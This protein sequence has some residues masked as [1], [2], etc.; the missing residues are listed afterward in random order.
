MKELLQKLICFYLYYLHMTILLHIFVLNVMYKHVTYAGES[1]KTI[2]L[3][4]FKTLSLHT[5][6][7]YEY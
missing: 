1:L 5:K 6:S 7:H 3:K 2:L 4:Y